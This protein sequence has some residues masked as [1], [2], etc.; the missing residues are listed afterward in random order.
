VNRLCHSS[1]DSFTPASGA[2]EHH[3]G[4]QAGL[5]IA[6]LSSEWVRV[7]VNGQEYVIAAACPHRKGRLVYGYVNV[8]KLRITCPLHGST[9]DLATGRPVAGPTADSLPVRGPRASCPDSDPGAD[10]RRG[11][12]NVHPDAG[13]PTRGAT[14]QPDSRS[15][16]DVNRL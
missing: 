5:V 2:S 10:T 9:F 15:T 16:H 12:D 3:S 4:A 6:P 14:R 1:G 13:T 8:R 7:E 11:I